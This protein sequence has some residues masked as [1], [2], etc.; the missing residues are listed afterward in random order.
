MAIAPFAP[1]LL[2][3]L[4]LLLLAGSGSVRA[5]RRAEP[6][7][8]P[9]EIGGEPP[10][11]VQCLRGFCNATVQSCTCTSCPCYGLFSCTC[12]RGPHGGCNAPCLREAA[13]DCAVARDGEGLAAGIMVMFLSFSLIGAPVL[14][15]LSCRVMDCLERRRRGRRRAAAKHQSYIVNSGGGGGGGGGDDKEKTIRARNKQRNFFFLPVMIEG[16]AGRYARATR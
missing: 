13:T 2:L 12:E 11:R 5:E 4:L 15:Y 9:C 8:V 1:L 7:F 3:L 16:G 6:D 10:L 14:M